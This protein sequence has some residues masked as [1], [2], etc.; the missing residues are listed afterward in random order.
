[1][2]WT[3]TDET[4]PPPVGVWI[5]WQ[6]VPRECEGAWVFQDRVE[7][8][9]HIFGAAPEA[10]GTWPEDGEQW[11]YLGPGVVP[12]P[13]H[14]ELGDPIGVWLPVTADRKGPVVPKGH[15][16]A[17]R[18]RSGEQRTRQASVRLR[19]WKWSS[20]DITHVCIG[21]KFTPPPFVAMTDER[22]AEIAE[23]ILERIADEFGRDE[24]RAVIRALA[25]LRGAA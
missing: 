4:T 8:N 23:T 21:P 12:T 7:H 16:Y 17:F 25:K 11:M 6:Q 14:T 9:I 19:N 24:Q 13:T 20:P 10:P 3:K 15:A 5:D 1:M 22:A 18:Y 2:T